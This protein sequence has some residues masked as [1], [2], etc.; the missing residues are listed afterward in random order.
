MHLP[1]SIHIE[2]HVY[3]DLLTKY[4]L[5][6]PNYQMETLMRVV[7]R[8]QNMILPDARGYNKQFEIMSKEI[9]SEGS[10]IFRS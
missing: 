9:N 8:C 2:S 1:V 5:Y 7:I 3:I 10:E 4:K 6:V